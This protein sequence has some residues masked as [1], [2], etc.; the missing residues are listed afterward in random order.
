ME[1]VYMP[2]L[3]AVFWEFESPLGHQKICDCGEIGRHKRLK[4]SRLNRRAG[5][6]PA[7]RTNNWGCSSP[8]RAA[9]LQAVGSGFESCHLH[10][11]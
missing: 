2:V 11:Y 9:A 3:E 8:G 1:L 10:Q 6:I 4:I 5:S 7:S